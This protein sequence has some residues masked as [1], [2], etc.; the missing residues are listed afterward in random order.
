MEQSSRHTKWPLYQIRGYALNKMRQAQAQDQAQTFQINSIIEGDAL[1]VADKLPDRVFSAIITSPPYY[2][3]RKYGL[4]ANELGR[5]KNPIEYIARLADILN[6]LRHSL[7][8]DGTLWVVIGEKYIDGTPCRI[9]SKLTDALITDG[10]NFVQEVHWQKNNIMPSSYKSRF[11]TDYEKVLHFAKNKKYYFEPQ[12]EPYSEETVKE[13]GAFYNGKA[14]KDYEAAGAPDPS[15][16]KRNII[17]KSLPKTKIKQMP[18]I[19]GV[20]KAGGDNR[21]YSG[22][23]PPFTFGQGRL[24]RATWLINTEQFHGAHFAVFPIK[25]VERILYSSCPF[26]I[27]VTCNK[28]KKAVYTD[29]RLKPSKKSKSQQVRNLIGYEPQC[30]HEIFQTGTVLDPFIGVGTTAIAA[31]KLGR[32]WSGIELNPE[33]IKIAQ[34]RF[35]D[36]KHMKTYYDRSQKK[37]D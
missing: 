31:M 22:N 5:E 1:D 13:F 37:L 20:K 24:M 3:Q 4:G 27:C 6:R 35:A 9:P 33:Y 12:N 36:P 15:K 26:E 25:L 7:K 30:N 14:V 19:G 21:T 10:W 17:N 8:D 34:K 11:V 32:D 29:W 28:S 18:P 16:T 23:T 2:R